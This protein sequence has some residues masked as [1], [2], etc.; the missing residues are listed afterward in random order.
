MSGYVSRVGLACAGLWLSS[1]VC[2]QALQ[3]EPGVVV[4]FAT[5]SG[6]SVHSE[7]KSSGEVIF[8]SIRDDATGGQTMPT[9]GAPAPADWFG[10]RIDAAIAGSVKIDGATIR[11]AGQGGQAGLELLSN[12]SLNAVTITHSTLGLG[13][14]RN[15]SPVL[16]GF[17]LRDNAVGV[18]SS[19]ARAVIS[20][21]ETYGNSDFG[22]QNLTPPMLLTATSNWWGAPSGPLDPLD[23]PGGQGNRVSPG[24]LYGQYL[25]AVPLIDCVVVPSDGFYTVN[26]TTVSLNTRCR[27]ATEVRLS[28]SQLFSGATYSALT[29]NRGFT[30][31]STVGIKRTFAQFR[32]PQG[33][34]K[35]AVLELTLQGSGPQVQITAPSNGAVV[36]DPTARLDISALTSD[37]VAIQSVQFF[38]DGM[39]I[40]TDLTAPYATVFDT[41]GRANGTLRVLAIATNV[42]EAASSAFV[43]VEMRRPQGPGDTSPPVVS[44]LRFAG[45]PLLNGHTY[46]NPGVL[47]A[48]I[49]DDTV[50]RSAQLLINGIA[51][52]GGTRDQAVYA[53]PVTFDE[54]SNGAIDLVLTARD[55]AG[56]QTV[57]TR[58]GTLVLSEPAVPTITY[59]AADAVVRNNH[60]S[61]LGSANIGNR[62]QLYLDNQPIGQPISVGIG[63]SFSTSITLP[64]GGPHTLSADA[65]NAI[66]TSPRSAFVTFSYVIPPP[67]ILVTSPP[68]GAIVSGAISLAASTIDQRSGTNVEFFLNG[69]SIGVDNTAPFAVNVLT[70]SLS[71]GVKTVRALL[72]NSGAD[73]TEASS[74]FI[75]RR[76]PA[77]AQPFVPP[78][79]GSGLSAVPAI[80]SGNV[81]ITISGRMRETLS[82]ASMPNAALTLVLRTRGFDRRI[83][84][85]TNA[86]G[87]FTYTFTPQGADEGAYS[88]TAMHPNATPF[89]DTTPTGIATYTISRLTV[90]MARIGVAAPRGFPQVVPITVRNS[91]GQIAQNVRL[92]AIPADQPGGAL[93]A[94]ITFEDGGSSGIGADAQHTFNAILGSALTST[95]SGNVVV[96]VLEDSSGGLVRARTRLG[97]ELFPAEPVLTGAPTSVYTGV[98]RGQIASESFTVEN[99][100]L[101]AASN[102]QASLIPVGTGTVPTW[103]TLVS[104]SN[105]GS[106][107]VGERRTLE[108][109]FAPEVGVSDGVYEAKLRV[110]SG[111]AIGGDFFVTVAVNENGEGQVRF[112]AV[113]NFTATLDANNQPILGLTGARISL[114]NEVNPNIRATAITGA[115][116]EIIMGPLP[117]GRYTYQAQAPNHAPSRGRV[118]LRAGITVDERVFL[119]FTT[120]SFTWS[121]TPTTIPD[122]YDVTLSAVFSTLVPAPVV[123]IEPTSVNLPILNVGEFITG[124]FTITNHGLIRADDVVLAVPGPNPYYLIEL[125]GSV[126]NELAAAQSV[127][128]PYRV[129]ALQALPGSSANGVGQSLADWIQDKPLSPSANQQALA[130]PEGSGCGLFSAG[131]SLQFAFT[132]AAGDQRAG[133]AG[134][135]FVRAIGNS[136]SSSVAPTSIGGGGG[137][138]G[139]GGG[140]G[141]GGGG[142]VGSCGPDCGEGCSCSAGC[143]PP[144]DPPPDD[145]PPDGPPPPPCP[146]GKCCN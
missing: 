66:A 121:V 110:T 27:N 86:D 7:L 138:H 141:S 92:V 56:N 10:V 76:A 112:H 88:V 89:I 72:R 146:G 21:S 135:Q 73:T 29:P 114:Q 49:V 17:V 45:Q 125:F 102:I 75:F 83:N 3:I 71:E 69:V 78:Y 53:F 131:V 5:D 94:G 111:N 136:C 144:G 35:L 50:V 87:D 37:A 70:T 113:D 9:P 43:L 96:A 8:T 119:D 25:T 91:V 81:P 80:S 115:G 22:A 36:T 62:V 104:A 13:V 123:I 63:G 4:K 55:G 137:G 41:T 33:Q 20:A 100:G 58:S 47:T 67:S 101:V 127:T 44:N 38:V 129:T 6:M 16:T 14:V 19:S 60:L 132:C 117:P 65:T 64:G 95:P 28:E 97:Y 118:V 15:A 24:V 23:N 133:N 42:N 77:P 51:V 18:R 130:R 26:S 98:R 84:L 106:L 46:N 52:P 34:T 30:V 31:S 108:L 145:P 139:W 142:A 12:Q 40:A 61:V 134:A 68:A 126:P 48:T 116:G 11:Y 105:L 128:L 143:G 99:K 79:I 1:G 109:R 107:G 32:G 82:P 90:T 124:E 122:N 57:V 2:A 54:V 74:Q 93:P 120:V 103:I 140:G 39:R 85:V 59:P